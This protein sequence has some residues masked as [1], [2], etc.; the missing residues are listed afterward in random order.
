MLSSPEKHLRPLQ[1]TQNNAGHLLKRSGRR[2]H[3]TTVLQQLHWLPVTKRI[4]FKVMTLNYKA[5]H[6]ENCPDNLRT[7]LPLY[8]PT[9]NLGSSNDPCRIDVPTTKSYP[10]N[11]SVTAHGGNIWNKLPLDIRTCASLHGFKQI[12]ENSF[13]TG[14]WAIE[15]MD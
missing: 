5:L 7:M 3:I 4:D 9:R 14:P 11:R 2:D 6:E 10:R 1:V 15:K 13:Q 8:T 12:T